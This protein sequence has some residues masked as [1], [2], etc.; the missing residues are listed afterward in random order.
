[1]TV[2]LLMNNDVHTAVYYGSIP[3]ALLYD[4]AQFLP[5]QSAIRDISRWGRRKKDE[6]KKKK[7]TL[8]IVRPNTQKYS[9]SDC[10][11]A[12]AIECVTSI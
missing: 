7:K 2:F 3:D 4:R 11:T 6:R 8:I 10:I 9:H 12:Q 5:V 1:M